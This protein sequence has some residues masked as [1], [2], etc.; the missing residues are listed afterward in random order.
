[1]STT[2]RPSQPIPQS[3]GFWSLWDML[4]F[5][6][7]DFYE[8]TM[9]MRHTMTS[10]QDEQSKPGGIPSYTPID[11]KVFLKIMIRR[12]EELKESLAVL[13]TRLTIM[14]VDELQEKLKGLYPTMEGLGDGYSDIAVTLRR[15][16]TLTKLLALDSREQ[17]WF[18]PSSPLFG[19]DFAGKFKADGAFELDEAAKCLALGRPTA[20]TFH[21]MRI[22]EVG[23]R[24]LA[25]SLQIPDPIKPAERN[26]G[27]VLKAIWSGIEAK[28]PT[29]ASRISGDGSL[30]EDLHASL[31][32]VKNPWRNA[33]MHVEKKYTGDEAVHIFHAVSGFMKKLSSRMDEDGL[34]LA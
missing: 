9:S 31:D 3:H 11:D 34:P 19:A 2:R 17:E 23:I 22:M 33:T 1:M 28:W 21:L 16:L 5:N 27:I 32:A 29:D 30:F 4:S 15:E 10:L 14:A 25:R 26:W 12:G 6:A 20:A 8:V 24:A 13:G 18:E 7:A